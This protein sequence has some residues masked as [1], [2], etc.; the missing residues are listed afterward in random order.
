MAENQERLGLNRS[1]KTSFRRLLK[2]MEAAGVDVTGK[3]RIAADYVRSEERIDELRQ[4]EKTSRGKAR[5]AVTRSLNVVL[6]ERRRLHTQLFDKGASDED[7]E[8][9][10]EEVREARSTLEALAAWRAHFWEDDNSDGAELEER[11][12]PL[13]MSVLIDRTIE[14]EVGGYLAIA[15]SHR[16]ARTSFEMPAHVRLWLQD[17]RADHRGEEAVRYGEDPNKSI[18]F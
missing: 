9:S 10:S 3:E 17:E 15:Q 8:L 7:D 12:G 16:R 11:Y 18:L 6:A 14:D 1:Q 2:D 13:P 4:R 5:A